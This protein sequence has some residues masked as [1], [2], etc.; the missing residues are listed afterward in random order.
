MPTPVYRNNITQQ[1]ERATAA[2]LRNAAN[3]DPAELTNFIAAE[4]FEG[5]TI[6]PLKL[7]RVVCHC[8]R[9]VADTQFEGNWNG[10]LRIEIHS[11]V[12]EAKANG[13]SEDH[14]QRAGE[15]FSKFMTA[16]LPA[17]LS[18]ALADFTVQIATPTEQGW[19]IDVEARAWFS[20]L[21]I[22][23]NCCGSDID[24]S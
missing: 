4:I 13:G 24:M 3:A 15:I 21:Q 8:A 12:D 10:T 2:F 20:Y 18:N 19:G 5:I 14:H 23:V 1:L 16:T 7:K 11:D 9:A 17:D 6:A 22:E